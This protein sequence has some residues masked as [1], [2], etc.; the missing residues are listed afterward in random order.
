MISNQK[1]SAMTILAMA[2][3]IAATQASPF[4]GQCAQAPVIADFNIQKYLNVWYEIERSNVPFEY[5]LECVSANY[6]LL[7]PSS[8]SVHNSGTNKNTRAIKNAFG[9]ARCPNP[10]E[11][12][13]LLV[14]FDNSPVDGSY[15]V[16]TTDYETYSVV[17]SCTQIIPDL[18]K[19]E[20]IWILSR[21]PTLDAAVVNKLKSLLKQNNIDVSFFTATNQA[22]C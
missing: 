5:N 10:S 19:Y 22:N 1:L 17:Y 16:F 6:T 3:L 20:L 14:K 8:I 11:P 13:K 7:T 12:N 15:Q 2:M 4:I 21:T 18:V 9:V